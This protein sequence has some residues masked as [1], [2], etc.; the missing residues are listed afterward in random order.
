MRSSLKPVRR[1]ITAKWFAYED[2][3]AC[4]A[5]SGPEYPDLQRVKARL[6]TSAKV[7]GVA[8]FDRLA[9]SFAHNSSS[10]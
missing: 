7:N 4:P 8:H 9:P 6:G 3:H 2:N 10:V 1:P 5:T